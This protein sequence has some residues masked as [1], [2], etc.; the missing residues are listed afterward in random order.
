[1]TMERGRD[2]MKYRKYGDTF[3]LRLDRGEEICESLSALAA[4]EHIGL[5][6][7]SGMGAAN[8]LILAVYDSRA[9]RFNVNPYAGAYEVTAMSGN[10]TLKDGQP[11]VHIHLCAGDI[12]GNVVGGHLSRGVISVTAEIFVRVLPGE[13]ERSYDEELG[14]EILKLE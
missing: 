13:L 5:A 9:Q 8:E 7:I 6:Q 14:I 11:H 1:M 3:V 10:I 12:R 2:G 4:Q